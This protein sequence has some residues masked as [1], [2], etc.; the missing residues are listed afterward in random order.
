M[1]F[2]AATL[3]AIRRGEVTLAFRRWRRPTVRSGGTLLTAIGQL[4]I[5]G[6]TTVEREL[7]TEADARRAGYA[8]RE[9][10]LRELDARP[11]GEIYRVALGTLAPDPRTALREA[12]PAGAADLEALAARLRRLDQR[13]ARGAWTRR[14]LELIEAHPA[15]RAGDL[16]ARLAM[17]RDAFKVE[18]RKL[19]ALGLTESLEIGYR[20]SPRGDALLAFLRALG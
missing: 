12:V 1:I 18:V 19:K 6:V 4:G 9:A 17:D 5:D 10:L 13:S 2:R 7:V 8:S 3:D 20:L 11:E 16:A 14:A 15:E